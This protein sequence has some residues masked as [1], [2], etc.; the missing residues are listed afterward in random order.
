[1]DSQLA[2]AL[3]DVTYL[4]DA[5]PMLVEKLDAQSRAGWVAAEMEALYDPDLYFVKPENAW[6][7]L[8]LKGVRP[9][10]LGPAI[11]LAEW[12]EREA[13]VKDIPRSRLLKDEA[14]FEL[15][16]LQP[17]S[18]QELARARSVSN[19]FERS[20]A[21]AAILEAIKS[22]VTLDRK[23]LPQ[24]A[25]PERT[26]APADVVELLKVLLKRQC[27]AYGV[28]PKLIANSA[29]LEEIA[30]KDNADVPALHG[31]RHEVFGEAALRLKHGEL[32]LRLKDGAVDFI[33]IDAQPS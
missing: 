10:E 18:P 33:E 2:Y 7:R 12:R 29:D 24:I 20:S 19:G 27:E 14:I 23:A 1:T 25:K 11:K 9:K 22:G 30:K 21:G 13:Q 3:S 17:Q 16:R 15:A 32:A 26:K 8:K 28:A 5:Y 31:W 4:R 6:K